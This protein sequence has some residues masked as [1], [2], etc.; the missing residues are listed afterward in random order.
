MESRYFTRWDTNKARR[1]RIWVEYTLYETEE[2]NDQN[3][4][5]CS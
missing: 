3:I 2:E 5:S 4:I 1:A